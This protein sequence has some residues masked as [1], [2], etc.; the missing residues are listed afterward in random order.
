MNK[1]KID[2]SIGVGGPKRLRAKMPKGGLAVVGSR[3]ITGSTPAIDET[4]QKIF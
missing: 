4:D 3:K 1:R 2:G